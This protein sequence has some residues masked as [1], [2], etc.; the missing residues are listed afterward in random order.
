MGRDLDQD[1]EPLDIVDS[2]PAPAA[3]RRLAFLPLDAFSMISLTAAIEPLRSANRLLGRNAYEW[4][5]VAPGARPVRASSGLVLNSEIALEDVGQRIDRFEAYLV[6]TGAIREPENGAVLHA[7]LRR[8]A[9]Q[10]LVVGSLSAGAFVLAR[11]GL[12]QGYRCTVHWEYQAAFEETFPE[13]ECSPGLFV[14]DR[15]RW[16]GSGGISS[17]DMMLHM[18]AADHGPKLARRVA[19]N[20]QVDR[21]RNAAIE[22]RPGALGRLETLP[23]PVQQVVAL[24]RRN[25]EAPL[26][27]AALAEETGLNLRRIERLFQAHLGESPGQFYR[28]LRLERA[29]ELLTPHQPVG[30]GGGADDGLFVLL[31]LCDGLPAPT[32]HPPLRNPPP[33]RRGLSP[34]APTQRQAAGKHGTGAAVRPSFARPERRRD[35]A[36]GAPGGRQ[37]GRPDDQAARDL[38]PKMARA[39]GGGDGRGLRLHAERSRY[40]DAGGRAE[41]RAQRL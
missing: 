36:P 6:V 26:S 16:T 20:F 41:G 17:M 23:Q 35:A 14:I 10:G 5:I 11:A 30:T 7:V 24:M 28:R 4:R 39:C 31:A 9:R 33:P 3:S 13:I 29:R 21:I 2:A 8:A 37:G 12:L 40:R 27:M 34:P 25:I 22:Q 38:H 19:N 18:I 32:R 1:A 15:N